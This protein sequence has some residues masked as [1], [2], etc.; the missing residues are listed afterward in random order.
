MT[1]SAKGGMFCK[2][3]LLSIAYSRVDI[4]PVNAEPSGVKC[5]NIKPTGKEAVVRF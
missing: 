2:L 5:G 3:E 4:Y 1:P